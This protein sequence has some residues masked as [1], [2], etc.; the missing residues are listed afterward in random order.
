MSMFCWELMYLWTSFV[1]AVA[2]APPPLI[3]SIYSH[4][5]SHYASVVCSDDIL[6]KFWEIEESSGNLPAL[7]VEECS[8]VQHFKT[9]HSHTSTRRFIVPLPRKPDAKAIGESRSQAVRRFLAL[10]HSFR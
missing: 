2:V 4:V 8:V 5:A 9:N 3:N 10:E 7:T 6:H 1:M